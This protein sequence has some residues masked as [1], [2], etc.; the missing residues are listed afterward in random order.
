M[1]LSLWSRRNFEV[2]A[3]HVIILSMK[4]EFMFTDDDEVLTGDRKAV[5]RVEVARVTTNGKN[6]IVL[7][8]DDESEEFDGTESDILNK[9]RRKLL[10]FLQRA[11]E[12]RIKKLELNS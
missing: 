1:S 10:N 11:E 2:L 3:T 12:T 4:L 7:S 9:H 6:Q 8:I 5:A